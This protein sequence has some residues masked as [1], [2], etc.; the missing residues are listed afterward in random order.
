MKIYESYGITDFIICSGYKSSEIKKYF[1]NYKLL[2]CDIDFD[3]SSG[4][5]NI[6]KGN[7]ENWN[8]KVIDMKKPYRRKVKRINEYIKN[9]DYFLM[10]YGDGLANVNISDLIKFHSR[11]EN[12]LQ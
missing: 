7:I 9:D 8:I 11:M 12:L 4:T 3:I 5:F 1:L 2:N 6:I 10:T